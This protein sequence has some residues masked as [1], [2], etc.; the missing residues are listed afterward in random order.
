MNISSNNNN[1][2]NN[3][4]HLDLTTLLPIHYIQR[5]YVIEIKCFF[6]EI[7]V[8]I[9]AIWLLFTQFSYSFQFQHRYYIL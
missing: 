6:T 1:N 5:K 2:N 8:L 7:F 4:T 9:S 3:Q